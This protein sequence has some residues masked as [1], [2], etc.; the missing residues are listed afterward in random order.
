TG[1]LIAIGTLVIEASFDTSQELAATMGFVVFSLFNIVFG[2]SAR[3]EKGTVFNRDNVSDRRQLGL[4][5][6]ALLLTFLATELNFLQRILNTIPLSGDQWLLC[7]GVALALL[8][9][10]EVIKFFMRRRRN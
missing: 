7:I 5:G 10:D 8:L 9:I 3:S 1:L 2:L 6:L 4:Y